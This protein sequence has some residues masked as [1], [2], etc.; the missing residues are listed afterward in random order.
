MGEKG[1]ELVNLPA[2][3]QV[4]P[5]GSSRSNTFNV[6]ANYTQRQDPASIR[7]DLE[8]IMMRLAT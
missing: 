5:T 3:A 2:G 4:T 8:A 1:P 6:T 7:L